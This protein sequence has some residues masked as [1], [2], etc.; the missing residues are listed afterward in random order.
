VGTPIL[1]VHGVGSCRET[2]GDIPERLAAL[3][4]TVIAVDLLGHGTSGHG[5]G[6]YSLGANATVM[7]D[8]LNHLGIDRAH[9]VGHSLGGGVCLQFAYQYAERLASLTLVSSGGLGTEVSPGLRAA[10]LPGA[11][12]VMSVACSAPVVRALRFVDAVAVGIGKSPV[13]GDHALGRFER[14][15]DPERLAAFLATVRS[16]VGREGQRVS[17]LQHLGRIEP[18]RVLLIW[19]DADSMVPVE[20]GRNA[21]EVLP[22]SRFVV[23][24]GAKHHPHNEDPELVTQ[25]ISRHVTKWDESN[26]LT[27]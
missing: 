10:T 9:A 5:N 19:G 15:Q 23:V 1:L 20:H 16:V 18:S 14:L 8:L 24:P 26:A 4:R 12:F 25:E 13:I 21:A 6:D 11:D 3:G 17:A 22:G 7:R 2:W 27:A